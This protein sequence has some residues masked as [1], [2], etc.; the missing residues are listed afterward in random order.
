MVENK[1]TI[2]GSADDGEGQEEV[3]RAE[4]ADE[5]DGRDEIRQRC[6]LVVV[7]ARGGAGS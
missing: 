1:P 5:D 4:D 6:S 7:P 2:A 3:E